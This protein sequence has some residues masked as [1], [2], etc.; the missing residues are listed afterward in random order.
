MNIYLLITGIITVIYILLIFNFISGWLKLKEHRKGRIDPS[1]IFTSI[2]I[3]AKNEEKNIHQLFK[4]LIN[5]T[6]DSKSFEIIFINDNSSDNTFNIAQTYKKQL[7]NLIVLD[8]NKA[9][10]KKAAIN[11]GIK[12]AKGELIITTDADCTHHK[13][14]LEMVISF[15]TEEKPKMVIAPV[16]MHGNSFFEKI[17]SLDF[18]SLIASSAGAVGINQPI[19]CNAANMAFEK[20]IY[21]SLENPHNVKY[22]SGDDVFLMLK[23]KKFSLNHIKFI[24]A[25]EAVC[26]TKAKSTFKGFI[27]QRIRWVSKS[28]GYK[29]PFLILTSI[30]VLL[31]NLSILL[32]FLFFIFGKLSFGCF[33]GQFSLKSI[34]DLIFLFLTSSFFKQKELLIYFIPTQ[35]FNLVIVPFLSIAGLLSK[36][37]WKGN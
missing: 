30:T 26:L 27:N 25:R 8:L 11:Y 36:G 7:S 5:Q 22:T 4:S 20:T 29:D 13:K 9:R 16:I 28:K 33:I 3:A 37:E 10:G 32:N 21:D 19:M 23:I 2:V 35:I 15:Y 14:W 24:K 6:I 34:I 17:Q 18:F 31:I 1:A 12:H